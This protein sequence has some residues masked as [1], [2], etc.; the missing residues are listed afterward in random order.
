M[1][2]I[3]IFLSIVTAIVILVIVGLVF[4]SLS[5]LSISKRKQ[6]FVEIDTGTSQSIA[7]GSYEKL[8]KETVKSYIT[9]S[10][11]VLDWFAY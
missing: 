7:F 2:Q 5:K 3:F 6:P 1:S 10:E 8:N 4:I 9:A 11:K